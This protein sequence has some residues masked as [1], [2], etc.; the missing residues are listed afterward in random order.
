MCGVLFAGI[1][2]QKEKILNILS[3]YD[4]GI[5]RASPCVDIN[6]AAAVLKIHPRNH[7]S[8]YIINSIFKAG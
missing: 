3:I 6:A 8:G 4:A 5:G 2:C 1:L 7:I